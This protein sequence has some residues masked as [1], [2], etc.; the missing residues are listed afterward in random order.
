MRSRWWAIAG[1]AIA[2]LL[3]VNLHFTSSN[4]VEPSRT[5]NRAAAAANA[6]P[7]IINSAPKL[8]A[9]EREIGVEDVRNPFSAKSWFVQPPPTTIMA[10]PPPPPPSAPPLPFAFAGSLETDPGHVV[11]YLMQGE[12]SFAVTPGDAFAGQ[13]KLEGTDNNRL[14][15]T[16]LPLGVKQFLPVAT[17]F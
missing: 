16:Y 7:L 6:A 1:I 13:Y 3:W 15:I 10:P 2:G 17:D 8:L 9:V 4:A 11:F 12:Q 5:S 14:V